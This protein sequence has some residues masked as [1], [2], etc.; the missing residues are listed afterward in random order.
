MQ[1]KSAAKLAGK[2]NSF[3]VGGPRLLSEANHADEKPHLIDPTRSDPGRYLRWS[4]T[5]D[6]SILVPQTIAG[7]DAVEGVETIRCLALNR[8]GLVAA[9]TKEL[10]ILRAQRTRILEDLEA[11]LKDPAALH[12]DVK[13]ALRG[14]EDMNARCK[15]EVEFSAMASAFVEAF[16]QELLAWL[17]QNAPALVPLEEV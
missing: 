1:A 7:Q 13:Y 3:P 15:P 4:H 8:V 5:S 10:N 16:R 17:K 11:G 6:Y 12:K 14:V 2:A 9:R